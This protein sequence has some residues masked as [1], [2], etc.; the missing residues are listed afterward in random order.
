MDNLPTTVLDVLLSRVLQET[1]AAWLLLDEQGLLIGKGGNLKAFGLDEIKIGCVTQEQAV[2]LDGILSMEEPLSQIDSVQI[3]SGE[4]ADIYT[5]TQNLDRWVILLGRTES[6]RWK[7]IA[8]QKTNDLQLLQKQIDTAS[9]I[10]LNQLLDIIVL[11]Q[12]SD[13]SFI[14]LESVPDSFS[15][16]LQNKN[17]LKPNES[18]AFL[19]NFLDDCQTIWDAGKNEKYKSGPWIDVD[20][21]GKE[22]ALEATATLWQ[23]RK[24]LLITR[25]GS[26][27]QEHQAFLQHGRENEPS[28]K[29]L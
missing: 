11:E 25:L 22:Y 2:F 6:S 21:Q 26:D 1:S 10:N 8:R 23:Q 3:D 27:Y 18:F 7:D 16:L 9:K 5:V 19:T 14:L 13:L 20:P 15:T 12:T 17:V 4:Y 24:I 28:Q 29:R